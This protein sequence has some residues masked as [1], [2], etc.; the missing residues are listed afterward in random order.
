MKQFFTLVSEARGME[1]ADNGIQADQM[2]REYRAGNRPAVRFNATVYVHGKNRNYTQLNMPE[3]AQFA[4]SFKGAPFLAD[5][6]RK[7]SDRGGTIVDSRLVETA[8]GKKAIVQTID[9]VKPWAVEG[10]LDGT[11]DRYSI[12]WNAE[13]Y[14]CTVCDTDFFDPDHAHSIYDIGSK[15]KKTGKTIEV[16]MKGLEGMET[17]AVTHPA[18]PGT[19]T[20][21]F[22][23][24]MTELSEQRASGRSGIRPARTGS[25]QEDSMK[26]K[27]Y[28]LLG[29]A[30]DIAEP[31]ALAT[32]EKRLKVPAPVVPAELATAL[33]L[34]AD[35]TVGEAT[36]KAYS[37]VPREDVEK[38]RAKVAE[39]KA[40]ELVRAGKAAGKITPI[41]EEW[42]RTFARRD[43]AEFEKCLTSMPVQVPG[44]PKPET[45]DP[46]VTTESAE[47]EEFRLSTG[48][49]KDEWNAA[50]ASSARAN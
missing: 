49:S 40:D 35:A 16:L 12:G 44:A 42:A 26:E 23:A 29:L 4:E 31:E 13:E 37:L 7:Q 6:S 33:G 18:V 36:A 14:I 39:L 22:L 46:K 11:V 45:T 34:S 41:M 3:L 21:G 25:T 20:D 2:L 9:A 8:D 32:L 28:S 38:E 30:A 17:S 47:D 19:S 24:Q 10:V 1:L 48:L 50:K 15:D 5:H 43:P 27:V